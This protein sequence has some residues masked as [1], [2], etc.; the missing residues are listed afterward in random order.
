MCLEVF[1]KAVATLETASACI[2]GNFK[3]D[4]NFHFKKKLK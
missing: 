2:K 3:V 4:I 1:L